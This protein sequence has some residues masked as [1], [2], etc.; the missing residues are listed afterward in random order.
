L[1]DFD[2]LV[3]FFR[4][5]THVQVAQV[6]QHRFVIFAHPARKVRITQM[7]ISRRLWHI[8]QHTKTLLYRTLPLRRKLGLAAG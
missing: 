8:F 4:R 3:R 5:A 2:L 7:L 1:R 6:T